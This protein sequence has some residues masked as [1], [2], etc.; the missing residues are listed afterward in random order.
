MD[1]YENPGGA[2]RGFSGLPERW[3][4]SSRRAG[5]TE[6]IRFEAE[7]GECHMSAVTKRSIGA[8]LYEMMKTS[9]SH[10]FHLEYF[11]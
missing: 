11:A 2:F 1:K 4:R 8:F 6:N 9:T 10:P 3:L 7:S 5:T